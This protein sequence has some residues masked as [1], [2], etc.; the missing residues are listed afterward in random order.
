MVKNFKINFF[1][2]HSE[3]GLSTAI[4]SWA[5]KENIQEDENALNLI[6]GTGVTYLNYLWAKSLH[7]VVF[8]DLQAVELLHQKLFGGKTLFFSSLKILSCPNV[9]VSVVS[10]YSDVIQNDNP[11]VADEVANVQL[12]NLTDSVDVSLLRVPKHPPGV[13]IQPFHMTSSTL[14]PNIRD[15]FYKTHFALTD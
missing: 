11:V 14:I 2:F 6:F 13:K 5:E 1:R 8:D 9:A 10:S 12:R 15:K 7:F 4:T 3:L